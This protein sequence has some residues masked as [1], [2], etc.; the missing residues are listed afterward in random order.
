MIKYIAFA[1]SF[2]TLGFAAP[3]LAQ[4]EDDEPY[5]NE[6]IY[7]INLNS[8]GGLIGGAFFRSAYTINENWLQFGGLEIVEVK[9]PKEYR[10]YSYTTGDSFIRGKQNSLFVIR[11]HYGANLSCS[12]RPPNRVCR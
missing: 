11:P 4:S 12:V 8:N 3:A 7:G 6:L 2:L 10:V 5:R 1:I 9:H